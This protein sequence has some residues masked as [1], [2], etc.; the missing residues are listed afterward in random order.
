MLQS[1]GGLKILLTIDEWNTYQFTV[2]S[3][4][5]IGSPLASF[6]AWVATERKISERYPDERMQK[7][8]GQEGSMFS[9]QIRWASLWNQLVIQKTNVKNLPIHPIDRG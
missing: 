1:V 5:I 2:I 9:A 4:R 8:A 3:E 7:M 6:N